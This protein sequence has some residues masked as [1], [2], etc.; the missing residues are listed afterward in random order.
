MIMGVG[1]QRQEDV[2]AWQGLL[3]WAYIKMISVV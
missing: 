1:Q 2:Y 3:S